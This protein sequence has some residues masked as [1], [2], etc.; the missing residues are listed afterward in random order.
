MIDHLLVITHLENVNIFK[1]FK[2]YF[3]SNAGGDEY[4]QYHIAHIVA[5]F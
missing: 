5:E 1:D 4:W 3:N 2:K